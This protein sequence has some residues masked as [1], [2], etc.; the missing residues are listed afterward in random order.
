MAVSFLLFCLFVCL[1]LFDV[2]LFVLLPQKK[3]SIHNDE[4]MA[5]DTRIKVKFENVLSRGPF[6]QGD[7]FFYTG[8]L[9]CKHLQ[10]RRPFLAKHSNCFVFV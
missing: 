2:C 6:H 5:V 3:L 9:N 8:L 10:E 7:I 1:L 4:Q